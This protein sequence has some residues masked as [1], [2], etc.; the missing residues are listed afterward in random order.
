[1]PKINNVLVRVEA[2]VS[3]FADNVKLL[4]KIKTTTEDIITTRRLIKATDVVQQMTST[5]Q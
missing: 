5:V 4:T 3:L 2:S 1:M